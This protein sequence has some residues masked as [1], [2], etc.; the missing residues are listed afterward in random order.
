[1]KKKYKK[2]YEYAE[3]KEEKEELIDELFAK[4]GKVEKKQ[5]NEI[6]MGGLAG[7]LLGLFLNR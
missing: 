2:G 4:G 3:S 7:V 5:N 1:M 6:I